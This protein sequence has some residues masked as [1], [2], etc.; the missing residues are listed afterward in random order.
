MKVCAIS[1]LHGYLPKIEP[2]DLLLICGDIM[3]LSIQFNMPASLEWLSNEFIKWIEA[4]P[5]DHVIMIA[6]NHD[7]VFERA[8]RRAKATINH[9]KLTYLLNESTIYTSNEGEQITIFGTPYCKIFGNWPF[10]RTPEYLKEKYSEIPDG[11]DILISHDAPKIGQVGTILEG[12]WYGE[13]AGN[14]YLADE[15]KFKRPR[16]VFSGH[17]HSGEHS[18]TLFEGTKLYNVSIMNE[19]YEPLNKPL[20]IEI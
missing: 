5:V 3:P 15:I 8:S 17:I 11:V 18:L 16:W 13:D 7:A 4:L 9:N 10:M 12:R 1:D 14:I 2:C 20:Y 19:H 6:G